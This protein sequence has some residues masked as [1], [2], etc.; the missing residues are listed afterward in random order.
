MKKTALLLLILICGFANSNAAKVNLPDHGLCKDKYVSDFA[1]VL[2]P[3]QVDQL[4]T[5]LS[6]YQKTSSAEMAVVI[7]NSVSDYG[8]EN[9]IFDFSADLF[10]KWGI[11]KAVADNGILY[12]I[13]IKD[14]KGRIATGYGIGEGLPDIKANELI[15]SVHE[16]MKSGNYYDGINI[17]IDGVEKAIAK[18]G[19]ADKAAVTT[20]TEKKEQMK[21]DD[22]MANLGNWVLIILF[23][24]VFIVAPI[25]YI[26]YR[27]R[28]R[29]ARIRAEAA[30]KKKQ[31][32]DFIGYKEQLR[33]LILKCKELI[34]S[35]Q[36]MD[37]LQHHIIDN[38]QALINELDGGSRMANIGE[39]EFYTKPNK[40]Q[41][42]NERQNAINTVKATNSGLTDLIARRD[43]AL[44]DKRE[45][46]EF[47]T[48]V[49]DDIKLY[50]LNKIDQF[51]AALAFLQGYP[52]VLATLNTGFAEHAYADSK[53]KIAK[54]QA[55]AKAISD[56]AQRITFAIGIGAYDGVSSK[57]EA[58]RQAMKLCFSGAAV[59]AVIK[60]AEDLHAAIDGLKQN[61]DASIERLKEHAKIAANHSDVSSVSKEKVSSALGYT[62]KH[63]DDIIADW[64]YLQTVISQITRAIDS[65]D[66]DV[67]AA[68]QERQRIKREEEE[69]ER[70]RIRDIAIAAAAVEEAARR[71]REDSYSSSNNSSY[72]S[73][74]NDSSDFGGG[75]TGGGG[76]SDSW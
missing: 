59:E 42:I 11:G 27:V 39:Q 67:A 71:S 14:R 4:K 51:K 49:N 63:T 76:G 44:K 57:I 48:T 29:N 1:N 64:W 22:S 35:A 2:T 17:V 68:E 26:I 58:C 74:S 10:Q 5:K 30:A 16:Q 25:G 6:D 69:R 34:K 21:Q 36:G 52:K 45:A 55:D 66:N 28:K 65:C 46:I 56:E 41:L 61:N 3:E 75:S 40:E 13:A 47:E 9:D 50:I 62:P 15:K 43:E 7:V 38:A 12:V 73:S 8:Y 70:R 60:R 33:M 53:V 19:A 72:S 20:A 18:T 32:D 23:V 31:Y 54:Y 37:G 24:C